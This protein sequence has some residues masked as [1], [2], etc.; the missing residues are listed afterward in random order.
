MIIQ[1]AGGFQPVDRRILDY[2]LRVHRRDDALFSLDEIYD[3]FEKSEM[4]RPFWKQLA[5]HWERRHDMS[6]G[7]LLHL[8]PGVYEVPKGNRRTTPSLILRVA[9]FK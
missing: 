7:S 5:P 2:C 6:E 8:L 1:R 9:N 3:A 4:L